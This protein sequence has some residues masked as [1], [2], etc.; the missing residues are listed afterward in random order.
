MG[1]LR[2]QNAMM[3]V[4]QMIKVKQD[5]DIDPN[6]LTWRPFG[7]VPVDEMDDVQP[8]MQGLPLSADEMMIESDTDSDEEGDVENPRGGV[9]HLMPGMGDY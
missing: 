7:I 4:N 8:R 2:M 5:A 1:N 9:R 3:L 6:A